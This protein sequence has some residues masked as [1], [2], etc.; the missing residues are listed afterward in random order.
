MYWVAGSVLEYKWW[1]SRKLRSIWTQGHIT[2]R[3]HYMKINLDTGH[4]TCRGHYIKINLDTWFITCR[5]Q[6][7]QIVLFLQSHFFLDVN[8]KRIDARLRLKVLLIKDFPFIFAPSW[9]S[10]YLFPFIWY[11]E[12]LC[13]NEEGIKVW[14]LVIGGNYRNCFR[15]FITLPQALYWNTANIL[16]F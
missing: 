5:G 3:R 16:Y 9:F 7:K 15:Y 4:I 1:N 8:F 12:F 2:C 13:G 10:L 11:C 6:S 14:I